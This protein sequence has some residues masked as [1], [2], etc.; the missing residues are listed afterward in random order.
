MHIV[1]SSFLKA[2]FS[3]CCPICP[4]LSTSSLFSGS[5]SCTSEGTQSCLNQQINKQ[6]K[7]SGKKNVHLTFKRVD[8]NVAIQNICSVI[9]HRFKIIMW[10]EHNFFCIHMFFTAFILCVLILS[11]QTQIR[12]PNNTYIKPRCKVTKFKLKSC[13]SWVSIILFGL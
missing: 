6:Q 9:D 10:Y 3:K 1:T 8:L 2:P 12:R 13:L 11:R 4:P 7:H 5:I